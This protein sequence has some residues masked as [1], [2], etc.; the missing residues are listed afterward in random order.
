MTTP[1]LVTFKV[2]FYNQLSY[3]IPRLLQFITTTGENLRFSTARICFYD[4][5]V[6]VWVYPKSETIVFAFYLHVLCD[7]F[8]WQVSSMAQ[9]LSVLKPAFSLVADLTLD[10]AEHWHS[11][12]SEWHNQ[13]SGT[14]WRRVLGSFRNVKTLGVQRR[15][16]GGLT[17]SPRLDELEGPPLDSELLSELKELVCPET[18][19]SDFAPFIEK[20]RAAGRPTDLISSPFLGRNYVVQSSAGLQQV[21]T[22]GDDKR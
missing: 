19:H 11:V 4:G 9:I 7:H 12:T 21:S 22:V 5:G 8:E 1:R 17:C 18:R 6:A 13:A 10:Y 20:R 2:H 14:Q 16:V 15:L 3:H